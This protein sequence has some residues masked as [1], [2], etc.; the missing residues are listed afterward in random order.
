MADYITMESELQEVKTGESTVY[1]DAGTGEVVEALQDNR[2][3]W[4]ERKKGTLRLADVYDAA[5]MPE[6]ADKLK[7]CSTWLE[8]LTKGDLSKRELHH[9]NACK[10]RLCPICAARKAR[11]MGIRV[12]KIIAKAQVDHP[13]TQILFLTLTIENVPGDKLREALDLLTTAWRKLTK[14]RPFDRAVKGWFRALEVT[15]NRS[16][17]TYHPHVHAILLVEDAYFRRASGLYITQ[18]KWVDMWQQSLKV[19]YK[20]FVGIERTRAKDGKCKAMAAVLEA[21][22]YA[23]K[24]KEYISDKLPKAEAAKVAAVYTAALVRKRMT[25]LGGWLLDASQALELDVEADGDLVHDEDG[26]G[27]L[28]E[29]TA[30]LL[31]EYTWHFGVGDHLL[32]SRRENPDYQ[33]D[34]PA[35][36]G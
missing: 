10:Q 27:E 16:K 25:A 19:D 26:Q 9:F 7:S 29:A 32:K 11:I 14:R 23:T 36:Q 2:F 24:S 8:Y 21:S 18:A 17:D 31:E 5:A 3:P 34:K 4:R 13:N 12:S 28:T 15:R 22:K 20:P 35:G 33:G 1:V 30:E 6:Q